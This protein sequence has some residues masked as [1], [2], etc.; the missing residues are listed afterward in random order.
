MKKTILALALAG[1]TY[2]AIA[3]PVKPKPAATT[4]ST[5][6]KADTVKKKAVKHTKAKKTVKK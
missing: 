1:F 6:A 3:A 2:G 4:T 5:V